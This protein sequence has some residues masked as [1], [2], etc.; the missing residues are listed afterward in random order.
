M[1]VPAE[2][3]APEAQ[4]TVRELLDVA[5][6]RGLRVPDFFL[7]GHQKC[8]TT[9]LH[10]MLAAHPQVLMPEVKEPRF[11]A[12]D[13][14]S[15]LPPRT[16]EAKRLRTPEG[17]L[18]LFAAAG[19][20]QLVGEASPQYLRSLEAAANI[21]A[22]Q[23]DARL[24]AILREPAS[25]LRSFHQQMV[26]SEVE[27]QRDLR[28]A[29]ALEPARREGREIPRG[30][31]HPKSLLY[32]DHV[33]YVEQ[34]ERY[35]RLFASERMLVLVYDDFRADNE[36]TMRRVLAFLG[37]DE[38]VPV[39]AVETK[40]VK[41]ARS[42]TLYRVANAARRARVDSAAASPLGRAVN[43]LTPAA[44]RGERVRALWRRSL[45]TAPPAA[46]PALMLELR[47]RFAPEVRALGEHLGR[48]LVGLWG[49]D[50][51]A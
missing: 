6:A 13:L 23:P 43:A 24:I 45:Y 51:L 48:D 41:A 21:R 42:R 29:L 26:S 22:A 46:D 16:D 27:T 8:G 2:R 37:L 34:L 12:T 7:L 36:A 39:S 19:T 4:P 17:Y 11:F 25:F 44:L 3:A 50:D 47:C 32:S 28:K 20:E 35:E 10:Y 14:R 18:E 9:A 30:C 49:Y 15:P 31:H 40:P 38:T 33:H 1:T 5:A